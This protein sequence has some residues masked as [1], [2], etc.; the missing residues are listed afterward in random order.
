MATKTKNKKHNIKP[1]NNVLK[2]QKNTVQKNV[3]DI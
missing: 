2:Q 1:K 3:F